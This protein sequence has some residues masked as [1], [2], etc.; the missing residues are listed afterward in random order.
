MVP[1]NLGGNMKEFKINYH[2]L[3]QCD[4][5][6]KFCFG[7]M[8]RKYSQEDIINTFKSIVKLTN[9]VNL[10]GGEIF[11]NI[12]LLRELVEIGVRNNIQLSLITNGYILSNNLDDHRVRYIIN[13]V[14][15]I[16]V[17]IDSFNRLTNVDMGRH[18]SEKIVSLEKLKA[19]RE[20]CNKF[21]TKLKINTVVTQ[22]NLNEELGKK[23]K[24]IKPD[25]WKVI[26]VVSDDPNVK[27]DNS[28]FE[29]FI[30]TN[31]L[32]N[33]MKPEYSSKMRSS[34]IMVNN[35]GVLYYDGNHIDEINVNEIIEVYTRNPASAF[36]KIL[37][38]YGINIDYYFERYL[39]DGKLISFNKSKYLKTFNK[40]INTIKGNILFLDVE[41]ITPR[42]QDGMR[43]YMKYS[44][45]QL[46]LLYT[47][48]VVSNNLEVIEQV[49]DYVPLCKDLV[50]NLNSNSDIFKNFF[51]NFFKVLKKYKIRDIV[52]SGIDTE[53]NFIQD[54]I[55][56]IGSELNRRDYEMLQKLVNN[57][58]DIQ[59]VKRSGVFK[60]ESKK[61]A[62]RTVLDELHSTRP[63]LFY[64]TR[65]YNK[66]G[67]S[68]LTIA[69]LL[70]DIYI[71]YPNMDKQFLENTIQ[72]VKE[73][74]LDD[75]YDDFELAY[76]YEG[77][78][79][80]TIQKD[81]KGDI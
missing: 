22:A 19:L 11:L 50:D 57:L 72:T 15:Q 37:E 80:T 27:I 69:K 4:M 7:Q 48:L 33:N 17:S 62:S 14:K 45:T 77:L 18:V 76:I 66:D 42:P 54:C 13:N 71:E 41:S 29:A 6:C 32:D 21:R 61:T 9:S 23:I 60:T 44:T 73:Y 39:A 2:F 58:H 63:D 70:I 38:S 28:M 52:V 55:Y 1:V 47:G 46:H 10:A 81:I 51:R 31:K 53:R 74:C 67:K 5:Q 68:S 25:V 75:V 20:V 64:Y 24:L 12:D 49:D 43:K 40:Q 35:E 34:Y 16:G 59:S 78:L 65:D 36:Y 26:Q 3:N 8:N 79:H 56:Y 30:T